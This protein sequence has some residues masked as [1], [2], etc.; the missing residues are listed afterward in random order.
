MKHRVKIEDAKDRGYAPPGRTPREDTAS[1]MKF[2]KLP[3]S[4]PKDVTEEVG[5]LQF[6]VCSCSDR[7]EKRLDLRKKFIFTCDPEKA[8]DFDD[9]LSLWKDSLGRRVL[10]I[11]IADVSHYVTPGSAMDRE[12]QK[13]STSVYLADRVVP[14]LPEALSNGIC[15]LAP[16][17][18]R[19]TFSVFI[20]Y[21]RAGEPVKCKFAKSIIN[22][23]ARFTYEQV[24]GIIKGQGI[25][26]GLQVAVGSRENG[27]A[28]HQAVKP[29][30][31]KTVKAISDL[32]QQLRAK[33][34]A[35]GALD[36]EVPQTEV[37]LDD[38]GEMNGI[39]TYPY[40]E[41]HQMVE[42]CMVAA[43]EA[44]A[45]EL[46]TNGVKIIARYHDAPDPEKLMLLREEVRPLGIHCGNLENQKVFAQFMQSIK[47]KPLYPTLAVMILRSMK[48]AIYDSANM[49]H[50]GLAK[51]FYAHFTSPIRR[52]P[53][54]TLH[55]Q[56][57]AYLEAKAA[58][59]GE[60]VTTAH[61]VDANTLAKWASHATQ[62][63][64]R[65]TEAERSLLE[66]KK[67]RLLEEELAS[68]T[69]VDYD[70][71][72]SK[73]ERFGC[74][75][76]VPSIGVSGLVH[77]SA[78]SRKFVRY[79]QY[80]HTL[81]APGNESWKIGDVLRVRVA[82]VDFKNRRIDFTAV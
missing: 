2:Y 56:L 22:S 82:K 51:R 33:R 23:K 15:S 24:E 54:L 69:P 72:I 25:V 1:V 64:E 11:H 46:W 32:A 31:L 59:K 71:V 36:L 28:N 68:R 57:T 70:A 39:V 79:N 75:V 19:L 50:W 21:S 44:V 55:R 38:D 17:E 49:G 37:S 5:R 6:G 13:R 66:I 65:A 41:S 60:R 61:R 63:E 12:A 27:D 78:I 7:E 81:S 80:D 29:A 30:N 77:I 3:H 58:K 35:A 9:A 45:K 4:F 20:T 76:D 14:M 40:D 18:D 74:F 43:N 34:F 10:G 47:S 52:Y 53:D 48:R 73:C 16:G 62:M 42:E 8:R 26:S 67:Y